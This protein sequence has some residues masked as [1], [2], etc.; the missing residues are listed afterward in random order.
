MVTT[1]E[2]HNWSKCRDYISGGCPTPTD[3]YTTQPLQGSAAPNSWAN[4]LGWIRRKQA[5]SSPELLLVSWISWQLTQS[6]AVKMSQPWG[7]APSNCEPKQTFLSSYF[8]RYFVTSMREVTATEGKQ[9]FS[10]K[11]SLPWGHLE[12]LDL[13]W[14]STVPL[15]LDS[16]RNKKG[17]IIIPINSEPSPDFI[18]PSVAFPK[19]FSSRNYFPIL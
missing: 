10:S 6:P 11:V 18:L 2:I 14:L 8:F 4:Q 17:G 7:T 1:T 13:N 3:T 16:R 5:E 15:Y 12:L 9:K 19:T